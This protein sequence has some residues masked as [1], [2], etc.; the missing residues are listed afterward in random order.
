[1]KISEKIRLLRL[2]QNITQEQMAEKLHLTPQA[3]A[4]IEQGKTRLHVER[5]KQIANIFNIHSQELIDEKGLVLLINENGTNS[6]SIFYNSE[7]SLAVENEKL[8]LTISHQKELIIS[9]KNE[10]ELLKQ[11]LSLKQ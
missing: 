1:M 6:G 9:L 2:G 7:T 10:I 8:Q 11:I 5:I 4:K 3:Y